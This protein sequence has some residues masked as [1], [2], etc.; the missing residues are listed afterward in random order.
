[1]RVTRLERFAA[2]VKRHKHRWWKSYRVCCKCQ[3][4]VYKE[5]LWYRFEHALIIA[6]PD[7]KCHVCDTCMPSHAEAVI[8]FKNRV[9]FSDNL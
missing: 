1:M 4:Y 9:K 7:S 8:Y 6:V 3:D 2:S 5:D